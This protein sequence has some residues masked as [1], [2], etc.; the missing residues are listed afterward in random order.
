MTDTN[1][2]QVVKFVCGCCDGS[3]RMVWDADIGTDQECFSCD[4][5]GEVD[6]D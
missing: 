6:E 4:G 1:D 5:T 2:D 3:G